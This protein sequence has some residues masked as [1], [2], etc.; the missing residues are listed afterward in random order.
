V[1][2]RPLRPDDKPRLHRHFAR[3]S[4]ES[5]FMCYL[6]RAKEL[7][8]AEAHALADMDAAHGPALA[9]VLVESGEEEVIA[10][11][12]YSVIVRGIAEPAP[13]LRGLLCLSMCLP[14]L[15]NYRILP[16]VHWASIPV[17]LPQKA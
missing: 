1:I 12:S 4:A 10:V 5:V 11:A 9:T 7:A 13:L 17:G 6:S 15:P 16:G 14:N 3:L 8:Q 2:L